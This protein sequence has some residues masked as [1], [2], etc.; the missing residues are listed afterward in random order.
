LIR[1]LEGNVRLIYVI[2]AIGALT[3]P[4]IGLS[5]SRGSFGYQDADNP[6]EAVGMMKTTMYAAQAMKR[7]CQTRHPDLSKEINSKLSA[8]EKAEAEVLRKANFHWS[9]MEKKEPKLRDAPAQVEAAVKGQ[10]E[11]L[12]KTRMA[13]AKAVIRQYCQNYFT[14]LA[15]GIWRKRTPRAYAYMDKAPGK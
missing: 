5:Q 3:V 2:A 7:E 6:S 14:D 12:E 9:V 1:L 11:V 10:F 4:C 8:W 13:E 15:S